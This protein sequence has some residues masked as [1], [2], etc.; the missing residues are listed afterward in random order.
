MVRGALGLTVRDLSVHPAVGTSSGAC[1]PPY[2]RVKNP[3]E[4]DREP[5]PYW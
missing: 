1:T 5:A 2:R 3:P 4:A